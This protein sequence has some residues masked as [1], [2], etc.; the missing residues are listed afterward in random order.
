MV[1]A[2]PGGGAPLSQLDAPADGGWG[3]NSRGVGVCEN[4]GDCPLF[5]CGLEVGKR[6]ENGDADAGFP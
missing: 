4:N 2:S 6:G 1:L 5:I 3:E